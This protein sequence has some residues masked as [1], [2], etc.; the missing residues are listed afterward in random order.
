MKN[1]THV[2]RGK[3]LK[4]ARVAAGLRAEDAAHRL[5]VASSSVRAHENGQNGFPP[6]MAVMYGELYGVSPESLLFGVATPDVMTSPHFRAALSPVSMVSDGKGN[7]RLQI[8]KSVPM[9]VA[10]KVLALLEGGE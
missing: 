5:G 3:A 8:D 10:L 7:A 9:S 1:P 2:E 6:D 4:A